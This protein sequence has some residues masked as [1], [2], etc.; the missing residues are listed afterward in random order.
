MVLRKFGGVV[1]VCRWYCRSN[2]RKGGQ[3]S[4]KLGE[5]EVVAMSGLMF[6]RWDGSPGLRPDVR[7]LDSVK[8]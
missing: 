8:D 5:V 2:F 4:E 6:G 7:R 1:E 3:N